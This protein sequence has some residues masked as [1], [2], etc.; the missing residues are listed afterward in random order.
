MRASVDAGAIWCVN[1]GNPDKLIDR[2]RP[3]IKEVGRIYGPPLLETFESHAMG[4]AVFSKALRPINEATLTV[5]RSAPTQH[6][7]E[8]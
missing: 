2:A 1:T 6:A 3:V 5:R 4:Q 8:N 7:I